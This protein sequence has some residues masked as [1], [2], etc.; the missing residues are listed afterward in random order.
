VGFA[1]GHGILFLLSAKETRVMKP[2]F[3][4]VA[5]LLMTVAVR[6]QLAGTVG[7][8]VAKEKQAK[9]KFEV[10]YRAK[11][12]SRTSDFGSMHFIAHKKYRSLQ[13][14]DLSMQGVGFSKWSG[15]HPGK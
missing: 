14:K 12:D 13:T 4:I 6:A 11:T 7:V 5:W 15:P 9:G 2:V 10:N 3:W 8:P 1:P